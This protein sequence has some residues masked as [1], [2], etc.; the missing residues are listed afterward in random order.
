MV[1]K[2]S[3]DSTVRARLAMRERAKRQDAAGYRRV[4]IALSPPAIEVVER[5][6]ASK[7]YKSR[8]AAINA[9]LERIGD[10]MFLQQEFLAVSG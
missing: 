10:D 8:E 9:I 1:S 2:A 5:V 7:G 4:T 6:K 3:N